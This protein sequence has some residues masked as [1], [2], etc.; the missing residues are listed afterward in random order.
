MLPPTT[1]YWPGSTT[2]ALTM[3]GTATPITEPITVE[4]I[5][6]VTASH[7]NRHPLHHPW[8]SPWTNSG[9]AGPTWWAPPST[10]GFWPQGQAS[11][12]S[13]SGPRSI[14]AWAPKAP[15]WPRATA[16]PNLPSAV[17]VV[18][19]M[20]IWGWPSNMS[21]LTASRPG[22]SLLF[23]SFSTCATGPT[24]CYFP[25]PCKKFGKVFSNEIDP[26]GLRP[27]VLPETLRC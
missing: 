18:R 12:T 21:A 22:S 26:F 14:S 20:T 3:P 1:P 10:L 2:G 11:R 24:T 16:R 5:T 6:I 13:P 9:A 19:P 4:A 25:M 7:N 15:L 17:C 27:L 23:S 8:P